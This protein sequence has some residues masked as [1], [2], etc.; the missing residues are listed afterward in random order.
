MSVCA[1]PPVAQDIESPRALPS[2]ALGPAK[3]GHQLKQ[4][5]SGKAGRRGGERHNGRSRIAGPSHV[6]LASSPFV[7]LGRAPPQVL[8][9]CSGRI[10]DPTTEKAGCTGRENGHAAREV[11]K[12]TVVGCGIDRQAHVDDGDEI[13]VGQTIEQQPSIVIVGAAEDQ[14]ASFEGIAAER[15]ADPTLQRNDADA[16][17]EFRDFAGDDLDLRVHG[18]R[19]GSARAVETIEIR[20]VDNVFIEQSEATDPQ[21]REE[22]GGRASGSAAT[23]HSDPHGSQPSV[24]RRAEGERLTREKVGIESFA[25]RGV[26]SEAFTDDPDGVGIDWAVKVG[27]PP[28]CHVI[29]AGQKD[30]DEFRFVAVAVARKPKEVVL[31]AV[32]LRGESCG[33]MWMRMDDAGHEPFIL[34]PLQEPDVGGGGPG[35]MTLAGRHRVFTGDGKDGV[36]GE[37]VSPLTLPGVGLDAG[38]PAE[39]IGGGFD[40]V[41]AHD[42]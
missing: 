17:A 24:E 28:R 33:S 12:V 2:V 19:I 31:V 23:H 8:I 41:F 9:A 7:L 11:A 38:L 16:D 4:L 20:Y 30:A 3:T 14:V 13:K 6:S 25:G 5:V 21:S 39:Y 27:P 36:D 34:G 26:N 29:A 32:V 10:D 35:D 42:E 1:W 40:A 18:V 22:H 37:A 15:V